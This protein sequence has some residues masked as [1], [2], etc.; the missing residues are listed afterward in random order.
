MGSIDKE[1]REE[2][3]KYLKRIAKENPLVSDIYQ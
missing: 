3:K 1:K 2:I